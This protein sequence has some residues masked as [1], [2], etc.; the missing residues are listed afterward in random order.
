MVFQDLWG[1]DREPSVHEGV[2]AFLSVDRGV[3][4]AENNLLARVPLIADLNGD[5][6]VEP[7]PVALTPDD[8]GAGTKT[9]VLLRAESAQL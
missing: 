8:P 6:P 5:R 4:F 7:E 1:I 2:D 3:G 9:D